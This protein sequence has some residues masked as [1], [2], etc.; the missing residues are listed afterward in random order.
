LY[1]NQTDLY[2]TRNTEATAA[3]AIKTEA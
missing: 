2:G 1:N 3:V